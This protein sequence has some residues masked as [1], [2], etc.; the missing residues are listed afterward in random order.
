M[1]HGQQN[2]YKKIEL[3]FSAAVTYLLIQ[4]R[5][6]LLISNLHK[7]SFLLFIP[8]MFLKSMYYPTNALHDATHMTYINSCVFRHRGTIL[9][10]LQGGSNMTGTDLYVNKPHCAAAV[11]P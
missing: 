11:R 9:S 10:E 7:R 1:M 3:Y 6:S 4:L 5:L 8:C 2:I